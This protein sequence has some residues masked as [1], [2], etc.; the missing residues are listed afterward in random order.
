MNAPSLSQLAVTFGIVCLFAFVDDIRDGV[1]ARP[2][3]LWAALGVSLACII[4]L[5]CCQ[6]VARKV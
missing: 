1:R 6:G 2:G 3:I 4:A 5:A